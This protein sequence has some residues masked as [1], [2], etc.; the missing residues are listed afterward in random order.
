LKYE[1][2]IFVNGRLH[3]R[4]VEART[5]LVEF[6]RD[7]LG[8][9]GTHV[10]CD[11][12]ACGAC[13]VHLNGKAVKSCNLLALQAD[14]ASVTTVEG[15]APDAGSPSGSSATGLHPLQEALWERHA[16][17][18]GY[19]ASGL[20][21]VAKDLLDGVGEPTREMIRRALDGTLCAC[22]GY[23]HAIEAVEDAAARP[24]ASSED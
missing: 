22:A 12:G 19:C 13:T 14:G 6:L 20:A 9:T 21:L 23:Q 5:L 1:L 2:R 7:E 18:C 24:R 15:M 4:Q 16:A 17:P 8:L 10:G 11:G 3:E